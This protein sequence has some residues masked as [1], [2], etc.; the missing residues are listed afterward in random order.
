MRR[1]TRALTALI[2]LALVALPLAGCDRSAGTP[3]PVPPSAASTATRG[4]IVF[5]M[6]HG[7]I[8]APTDTSEL[9]QSQ[10][11]DQMRAA[12]FDVVINR[13]AITEADL[14]SAS[15]LIIAGPMAPFTEDEYAAINAFVER[16][17]TVLLTIHVPFPVMG[18]PAHWGLPVGAEI[19]MSQQPAYNPNEP[20][21]FVAT[22]ML[23][24][25]RL[26]R[27]VSEVLV[28]S[29]W[30][31]GVTSPSA[32]IAVG[33]DQRVWLSAAGDQAP[34]PPADVAYDAY[35]VIGVAS[36][37]KGRVIV[38]GDDAIFANMALGVADNR[39][40]LGNI[41][42]LMAEMTEI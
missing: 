16:G 22:T 1:F 37:G 10:A 13:D 20:S 24:G 29:G 34:V 23:E 36:I 25:D 35:G 3:V 33:T 15:G 9:G 27:D 12:G 21:V 30:P 38:S 42:S 26:T 6:G 18:V 17:G 41:I 14:A 19:M 2:A 5:D 32:T 40:L 39:Q 7:E 31:V 8:F 28:V 11:V 4:T